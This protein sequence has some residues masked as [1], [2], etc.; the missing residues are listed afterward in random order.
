MHIE[1]IRT[2]HLANSAAY[3]VI[4]GQAIR[5]LQELEPDGDA[6]VGVYPA[7]ALPMTAVGLVA[8]N[9]AG[10]RL[11]VRA[12]M[13]LMAKLKPHKIE[14]FEFPWDVDAPR[15][16]FTTIVIQTTIPWEE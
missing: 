11:L 1:Y 13:T 3:Q 10:A 9:E 2:S 7:S 14:L 12:E 15:S 16:Q 6:Y 8:N 5:W 4:A